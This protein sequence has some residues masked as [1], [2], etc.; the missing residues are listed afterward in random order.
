VMPPAHRPHCRK[1]SVLCR[2]PNVARVQCVR[3][4]SPTNS[5]YSSRNQ[6]LAPGSS[7]I[8]RAP[9]IVLV[10]SF[11]LVPALE[12]PRH[13]AKIALGL[14]AGYSVRQKF[15]EGR[16]SPNIRNWSRVRGQAKSPVDLKASFARRVRLPKITLD[17]LVGAVV[18]RCG[19]IQ[20]VMLGRTCWAEEATNERHRRESSARSL[21]RQCRRSVWRAAQFLLLGQCGA[22]A[23]R[24]ALGFRAI[25]LSRQSFAILNS[26]KDYSFT[27]P[28]SVPSAIASSGTS[29]F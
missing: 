10:K 16:S 20:S 13:E 27:Y 7:M 14:R 29:A 24:A 4:F 19:M 1:M 18:V 21:S 22:R 15:K 23:H 9:G 25:R 6:S 5:G 2:R 3:S 28:G 11:R 8:S 17:L 12:G 26:R